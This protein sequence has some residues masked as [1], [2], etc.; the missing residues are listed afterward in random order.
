MSFRKRLSPLHSHSYASQEEP[1]ERSQQEVLI[2][3]PERVRGGLPIAAVG[4]G[5]AL[6]VSLSFTRTGEACMVLVAHCLDLSSFSNFRDFVGAQAEVPEGK[7]WKTLL[8]SALGSP[9]C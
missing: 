3:V 1:K 6:S 8:V 2:G 4:R 7:L 5:K 9:L